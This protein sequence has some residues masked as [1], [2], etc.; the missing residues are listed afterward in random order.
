MVE[1][2]TNAKNAIIVPTLS[3]LMLLAST[4][5]HISNPKGYSL[6]LESPSGFGLT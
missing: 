5:S 6:A 3:A 1:S 2:F 4:K